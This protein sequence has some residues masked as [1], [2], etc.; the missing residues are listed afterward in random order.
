MREKD[1]DGLRNLLRRMLT[2]GRR[3][4]VV[5]LERK[6]DWDVKWETW[7]FFK[8]SG[9]GSDYL[10]IAEIPYLLRPPNHTR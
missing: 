9:S 5:S 4:C 2:K 8:E 10:E 6:L 3:G 7:M 1:G